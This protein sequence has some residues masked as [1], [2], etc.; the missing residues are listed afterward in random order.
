MDRIDSPTVA[1]DL[2]GPGK[3]GFKDGDYKVGKPPT[4]LNAAWF[5]DFQEGPM[6]V[7]EAAQMAPES[8]NHEL[9]LA[10]ILWHI[11]MRIG[12][13][14]GSDL[15]AHIQNHNNPHG[16]TLAQLGAAAAADLLA[17]VNNRD[18]PHGVTLAQL[19]AAA[20]ADLLSHINNRNNPHGV[21][22]EQ[23]GGVPMAGFSQSFGDNGWCRLPNGWIYQWGRYLGVRGEGNGPIITFPMS[24]PNACFSVAAFD[25]NRSGAGAAQWHNVDC[26]IQVV[27][28]LS[29]S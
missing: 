22:F 10:A 20:A 13:G 28:D 17:H 1:R 11:N 27:N 15:L 14:V 26:F 18:N 12:S 19:G 8:G 5:N 23:L 3:H 9:F 6:R 21:T 29:P 25:W 4:E 24:F 16:V 2:F 7:I